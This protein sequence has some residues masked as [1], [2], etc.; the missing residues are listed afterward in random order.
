MLKSH[1]RSAVVSTAVVIVG[2]GVAMLLLGGTV[3]SLQVRIPDRAE[4]IVPPVQTAPGRLTFD[5]LVYQGAFRVP[6]DGN[7]GNFSY[8]GQTLAYNPV[9]NTLF[10]GSL[11]NSVAELSIPSPAK[12]ARV[13]ELPIAAF[14]QPFRDPS[15]GHLR[16]IKEEDVLLG[17]LL[18]HDGRLYVSGYIYY[19]AA[20]AQRLTHFSRSLDLSRPEVQRIHQV[21]ENGKAGFVA[22]YMASV[23]AE[24]R[25]ALG[26]PAV[27]GQ[28]CIP[29]IG[30]TSFG[31]GL[32]SWNPADLGRRDPVP[33][34]P[35]MYYTE[36]HATLG[37]WEGSNSRYGGTTQVAGVAIIDG[38]RT[39]L[40]AGRNGL[41]DFC[42][43]IGTDDAR[44][45]SQRGPNGETYCYDPTNLHNG[46]HAY[47]YRLQ[48]WAYDVAD[49]A[50]VRSG[51]KQPWQVVPYAVWPF[52]LPSFGEQ[53]PRLG[54]LTYDAAGRRLFISELFAER[55][56]YAHRPLIHV[57]VV[58]R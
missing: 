13:E 54:R 48:F 37:S 25:T 45:A 5:D 11:Q 1:A 43:G 58:R 17:G 56:G 39:A 32:F 57:Y 15:D 36:Q 10:V 47:P 41:G 55:D 34:T 28:C 7:G 22:G 31:P 35:L 16:D 46:S 21:G 2:L 44:K 23:P 4:P 53:Q 49:L 3:A 33:A 8:G 29:I 38:T 52:E 50:A 27:T 51:D 14:V 42:Y 40:F 9:S 24:W 18:V 12:A 30:R 20:H 26:G 19:D 6:A